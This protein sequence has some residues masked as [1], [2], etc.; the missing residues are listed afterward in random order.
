MVAKDIEAEAA[1]EY[2]LEHVTAA[3]A[4]IDNFRDTLSG[5]IDNMDEVKVA[6]FDTVR[7]R[8]SGRPVD[9]DKRVWAIRQ[10]TVAHAPEQP[11]LGF[12]GW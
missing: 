1:T 3:Q 11:V 2:L 6:G 4:G 12:H 10:V 9:E 7:W 8:Q 5:V